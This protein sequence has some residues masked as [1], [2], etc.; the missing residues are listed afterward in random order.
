MLD[1]AAQAGLGV[2][3][4]VSDALTDG[5]LAGIH[6]SRTKLFRRKRPALERRLEPEG[7]DTRVH[8]SVRERCAADD[9]YRPPNLVKLL[10]KH[11]DDWD[12]IVGD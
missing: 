7:I 10:S 8:P 6:P 4:H 2:E 3:G 5:T 1:E 11:E 12:R 9:T